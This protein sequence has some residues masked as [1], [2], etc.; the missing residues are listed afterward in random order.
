MGSSA[1][2]ERMR[3]P[4]RLKHAPSAACDVHHAVGQRL[5]PRVRRCVALSCHS[6][7]GQC[8]QRSAAA[9]LAP[10]QAFCHPQLRHGRQRKAGHAFLAPQRRRRRGCQRPLFFERLCVAQR[11]AAVG[12]RRRAGRQAVRVRLRARGGGESLR[13][14]A[15]GAPRAVAGG[16]GAAQAAPERAQPPLRH[17]GRH[18]VAQGQGGRTR[19]PSAAPA[20]GSERPW[21]DRALQRGRGRAGARG[22]RHRAPDADG[23]AEQTTVMTRRQSQTAFAAVQPPS[24]S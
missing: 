5:R 22:S 15:A 18:A 20:A 19:E 21:C 2:R 9:V 1:R 12:R 23:R 24:A 8:R 13:G 11:R 4:A 14:L 10:V 16:A 6:Q 17:G 3:P 7:K